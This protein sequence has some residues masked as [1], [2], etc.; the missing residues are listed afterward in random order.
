MREFYL[1]IN[2]A[3][4]DETSL[5]FE[6]ERYT[7]AQV[8]AKANRAA[9][10]FREFYGVHKGMRV[11]LALRN[12]PEWIIAFWAIN[13]LG[14]VPVLVRLPPSAVGDENTNLTRSSRSGQC[15]AARKGYPVL[16]SSHRMQ[17]NYS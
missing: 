17:I 1:G 3:F 2:L 6:K 4:K 10:V 7:F 13:L 12:Y 5:V 8:F 16:P 15:F 11:G 14:A 9:S